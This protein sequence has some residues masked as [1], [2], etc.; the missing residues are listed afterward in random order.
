[1]LQLESGFIFN[2]ESKQKLLPIM[3]TLLE[4]LNATGA[5]T[6]PIGISLCFTVCT[7]YSR[8]ISCKQPPLSLKHI[9]SMVVKYKWC[10]CYT[11]CEGLKVYSE[12]L[13]FSCSFCLFED[14]VAAAPKFLSKR[15]QIEFS[16]TVDWLKSQDT[17]VLLSKQFCK[18]WAANEFKHVL[19]DHS[20]GVF[21]GQIW[22]G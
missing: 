5:C 2:E 19:S 12:S 9:L 13:L 21:G 3:S 22:A 1:M 14:I 7:P 10:V 8:C 18:K 16:H 11:F 15:R 20:W 4:E 17:A 6:L